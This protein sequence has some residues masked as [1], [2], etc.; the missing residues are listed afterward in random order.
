MNTHMNLRETCKAIQSLKIQGA[1][2]VSTA[3]IKALLKVVK[4]TPEK[5]LIKEV[6]RARK[7]L[8][9]T[10]ATEP[11]LDNYTRHILTFLKK[12]K[13][14]KATMEEVV[15]LFNEKRLRRALIIDHG[16]K[17][18]HRNLNIFTHCRSTTVLDILK[19]A[20]KKHRLHILNTETRPLYQGRTTAK[21]L[22]Q[23]KIKVTHHVDSAMGEAVGNADIILLGADAITPK[24]V[25]NKIGS[26]TVALLGK[27][28]HVPVYICASLWKFTEKESIEERPGKEVW[29][30]PKGVKVH[31]PA[32]DIIPLK[33]VHAIICEQGALS[34]K[35]F[36]RKARKVTR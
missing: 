7:K 2:K 19:E 9:A 1:S 5:S 24:G 3:G 29:K 28:Q 34:P 20:A 4:D 16:A 8:L 21:E 13:S 10:R 31:N 18:I 6:T 23:A 11:E 33:Q 12:T 32:F 36:I 27:A 17:R 30:A 15:R 25:Y 22:A 14:K 35:Q 26:S